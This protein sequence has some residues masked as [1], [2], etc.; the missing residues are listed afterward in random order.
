MCWLPISSIARGRFI[1]PDGLVLR[2]MHGELSNEEVGNQF[3]EQYWG[4]SVNHDDEYGESFVVG[5]L[6]PG[7]YE[8]AFTHFHVYEQ[9]AVVQPGQL[10]LVAFC[11]N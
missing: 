8:I 5:D 9:Q 11:V 3:P 10:T 2:Y 7:T 4:N 6:P 1:K